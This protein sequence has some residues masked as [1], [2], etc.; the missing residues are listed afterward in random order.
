MYYPLYIEN[1]YCWLQYI[2]QSRYFACAAMTLEQRA[3]A[4]LHC[5]RNTA[6]HYSS[7]YVAPFAYTWL[8]CRSSSHDVSRCFLRSWLQTVDTRSSLWV[9]LHARLQLQQTANNA[10]RREQDE[11]KGPECH[12]HEPI[13][14]REYKLSTQ[15][16]R[17]WYVTRR[18][19][20]EKD[21]RIGSKGTIRLWDRKV[22]KT[23]GWKQWAFF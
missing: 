18:G 15:T 13:L 21:D 2:S 10:V 3:V 19:E 9:T 17:E 11:G 4:E 6:T 1:R 7:H 5:L 12:A 23:A 14:L 16:N 22:Y 8:E 20:D